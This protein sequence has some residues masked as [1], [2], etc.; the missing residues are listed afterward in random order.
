MQTEVFRLPTSLFAETPG[1]VSPIRA[2]VIQW[3]WKAADGPGDTKDDTEIMATLFLKLKEMYAK[4]GGAYAEP[5]QKLTWAYRIANKPSPEE[6]DDGVQRKALSD[7]LDPKDAIKVLV[8]AGDQPSLSFA[9]LRDADKPTSCGNWIY[10]GVWSRRPATTR[11]AGTT[12]IRPTRPMPELGLRLAR[13]PPHSPTTAPRPTSPAKPG[14]RNARC[15]AG[16]ARSGVATTS[17]TCARMLRRKRMSCPSSHPEGVGRLFSRDMMAE[18]PFPEHY[19]PFE[20][21]LAANPMH[22]NNPKA[23]SNKSAGSPPEASGRHGKPS[24]APRISRMWP[25]PTA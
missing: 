3:R 1:A 7:V 24:A 5:I 20:T 14:I 2:S 15:C 21:P 25:P 9:M 13:Q 12:A 16:M 17:P 22:P 23:K 19:E 8:K 6:L 18:G 4:D 11:R 10:C